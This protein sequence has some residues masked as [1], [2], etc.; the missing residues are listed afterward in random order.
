MLPDSGNVGINTRSP[1]QALFIAYGGAQIEQLPSPPALSY[2]IDGAA[3]STVYTYAVLAKDA[4][5]NRTTPSVQVVRDGPPTLSPSNAIRL[6]WDGV[7]GSTGYDVLRFVVNAWSLLGS[8]ASPFLTDAG[9]ST[10]A[11]VMPAHN[12]TGHLQASA[13]TAT[14][15][16]RP[17]SLAMPYLSH[18]G[19]HLFGVNH[20][21]DHLIPLGAIDMAARI[22]AATT[23]GG[24]WDDPSGSYTGQVAAWA[25]LVAGARGTGGVYYAYAKGLGAGDILPYAAIVEAW[26]GNGN[27]YSSG[28]EAA[29]C[30]EFDLAQGSHGAGRNIFRA[31]IISI[32]AS[33]AHITYV[34]TANEAALGARYLLNHTRP[35]T[36]TGAV[37]AV[38]VGQRET[39]VI[40]DGVAF[41]SSDVGKYLK[42][43]STEDC[44]PLPST[45]PVGDDV[46]MDQ[47]CVGHWYRVIGVPMPN[48]LVLAGRYDIEAFTMPNPTAPY[49]LMEGAE[50]T[51]FDIVDFATF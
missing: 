19:R 36:T 21:S 15:T 3:G 4:N 39:S 47:R 37:R 34:A 13:L 32:D 38:Y 16:G 9:E 22:D 26:G 11:Y 14:D 23:G 49:L 28:P 30:G 46:V 31:T 10:A 44:Y 40:F 5:G 6:T 12:E 41:G 7:P 25:N 1:D 35:T 50:I 42:I 20:L 17:P 43:G 24:S 51:S 29:A 27:L 33:G 2:G 45:G 18:E 48:T 8:S